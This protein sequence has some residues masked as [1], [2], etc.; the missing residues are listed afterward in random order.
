MSKKTDAINLLYLEPDQ[1]SI[2]KDLAHF[3]GPRSEH[4]LKIYEKKKAAKEPGHFA[5]TF[6]WVTFLTG[7]VWFFYRKMYLFGAITI[8]LPVGLSL[9]MEA[10]GIKD[11]GSSAM[12]IAFALF[13][14]QF[15][16]NKALE[17]LVKANEM[18]IFGDERDAY[19]KSAG[20]TSSIAGGIALFCF[21][22]IITAVLLTVIG[23]GGGGTM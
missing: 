8:I 4:F 20:G 5:M 11:P 18:G 23:N 22:L 17:H 15:Y 21:L 14:K 13:A 19:L 1:E 7:F 9:A 10:M 16:I 12:T 6:S 2:R 3:F